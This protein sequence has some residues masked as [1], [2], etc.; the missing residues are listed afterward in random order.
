[1]LIPD[2]SV[3]VPDNTICIPVH[4]KTFFLICWFSEKKCVYD[5]Q[6]YFNGDDWKPDA[7]KWCV[8]KDGEVM[9][10]EIAEGDE[11]S[12]KFLWQ[13]CVDWLKSHLKRFLLWQSFWWVKISPKRFLL[14]QSWRLVKISLERVFVV[15]KLL[16]G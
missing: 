10:T 12:S 11:F 13:S 8:C 15:I 1:L 2:L 9:C 16:I 3:Y 5:D 4:V 7:R 14:W 6:E